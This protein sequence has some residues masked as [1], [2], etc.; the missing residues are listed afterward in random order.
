MYEQDFADRL[1]EAGQVEAEAAA[2]RLQ[3]LDQRR[4][5]ARLAEETLAAMTGISPPYAV[6]GDLSRLSRGTA[7]VTAD[8]LTTR[9]G[10]DTG[11]L[12]LLFTQEGGGVTLDEEGRL[13]MPGKGAPDRTAV[14]RI[15]ARTVPIP[16]SWLPPADDP[17]DLPPA[18]RR[19]THLRDLVLLP[20]TR[21][22]HD[23]E[24]AS[25][26]GQ[27]DGRHI[28]FTRATGVERI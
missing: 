9:L 25:W 10:A 16:G 24:D 17:S 11:R 4:A 22:Q 15:V 26:H 5:G 20:M 28:Q 18:W 14:R 6:R 1:E 23:A 12:L 8:L 3:A 2:R 27:L 21:T 13:P 19:H 7:E